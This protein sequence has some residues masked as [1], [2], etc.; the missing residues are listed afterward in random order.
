M[1]VDEAIAGR[2]SVLHVSDAEVPRPVIEELLVAATWAP[3]HK[4]TEPWRFVVV[5]GD[6][7]RELGEAHADAVGAEGEARLGQIALTHRA[8]VIVVCIAHY[9]D[10]DPVRR[11]EDR[12]A[13]AAAVQ[14]LLLAA[15]A[16]GLGAIWR[17]GPFCDEV[18]VREHLG[19]ANGDDLVGFVYLGWPEQI[20]P[21]PSRRPV[22]EVTTWRG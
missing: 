18:P 9:E 16:R 3:N 8:P 14:N 11:R 22:E 19:V 15:H 13:V 17:T 21:N 20:P 1:N 6:A 4:L 5:A 7:R 12:D 2:R 10:A